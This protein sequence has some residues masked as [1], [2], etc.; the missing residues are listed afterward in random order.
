V[1]KGAR[2]QRDPYRTAWAERDP[3]GLGPGLEADLLGYAAVLVNPYAPG[4]TSY[5][6]TIIF[7]LTPSWW[8]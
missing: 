1:D 2:F 5:S 4:P 7:L 8:K 6:V 3:V